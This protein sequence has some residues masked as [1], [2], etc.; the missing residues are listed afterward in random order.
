[1]TRR[2]S[3]LRWRDELYNA[4]RDARGG[5][6][7]A[8]AFLTERRGISIHRE[9]LRRKLTGG[10]QLDLDVCFVLSEHLRGLVGSENRALS[11]LIAA[12]LQE[13]LHLI[14]MPPEPEGGFKDEVGAILQK[15]SVAMEEFGKLCGIANQAVADRHL[16][17]E[18]IAQIVEQAQLLSVLFQRLIRNVMRA[19]RKQR[20]E[21]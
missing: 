7:A 6:D 20:G 19:G 11:W 21:A 16:T 3:S 13:G 9:S 4:V 12:A 17:D 8:A 10:E 14:E 15:I 18:E 2:L 5:V 1:M